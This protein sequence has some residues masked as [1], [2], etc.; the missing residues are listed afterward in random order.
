M[1]QEM[2]GEIEKS[3]DEEEWRK[4]EV[5]ERRGGGKEKRGKILGL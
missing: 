2:E 5:E 3:G 4:E 1:F